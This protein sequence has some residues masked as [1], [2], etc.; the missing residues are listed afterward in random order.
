MFVRR[1]IVNAALPAEPLAGGLQHDSLAG[2]DLA[3]A[4][5]LLAGHYAGIGMRQQS[6]LAQYQRAHRGEIGDR[7]FVAEH[8]QCVARGLVSQLGLVAQ[9]KQR[10]GATCGRTGARNGEYLVG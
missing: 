6:G 1:T 7:G 9:R 2:S 8:L 5:D 4:G 10:F 3:Q